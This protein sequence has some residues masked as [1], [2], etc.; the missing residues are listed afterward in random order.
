MSHTEILQ[1]GPVINREPKHNNHVG[2]RVAAIGTAAATVVAGAAIYAELTFGRGGNGGENNNTITTSQSSSSKESSVV[3]SSKVESAV[4]STVSSM[5]SSEKEDLVAKEVLAKMPDLTGAKKVYQDNGLGKEGTY[6]AESGNQYGVEAN[7]FL[8]VY[9]ENIT[10][11]NEKVGGVALIPSVVSKLV[12]DK[13]NTLTDDQGKWT[14]FVPADIS[15]TKDK[16]AKIDMEIVSTKLPNSSSNAALKVDFN[17]EKVSIDNP[18]LNGQEVGINTTIKADFFS[19]PDMQNGIASYDHLTKSVIDQGENAVYGNL[20]I[21]NAVCGDKVNFGLKLA[22]TSDPIYICF[23]S[24]STYGQ[25][26]LSRVLVVD[27]SPVFAID[28]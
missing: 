8:G 18:I 6:I 1:G 9:R 11:E 15:E 19:Y 24:K 21:T 4:N 12:N 2:L 17:S 25:M 28:Q 10:L 3:S 27:K 5:T 7:K 23:V 16:D 22:E 26:D 14:V 20:N 13:L